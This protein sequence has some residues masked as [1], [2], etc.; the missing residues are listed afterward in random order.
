MR[1]FIL[2]AMFAT[3]LAHAAWT[4]Y[5]EV[6]DLKLDA[7]GLSELSIKAGA[8]S[9]DVKGVDGADSIEVKATIVVPNE[10]EDKALKIIEKNMT[11]SLD[12]KNGEARL[13]AWFDESFFGNGSNAHIAL[14]VSV[15]QG[16]S[17]NIDDGSGSIDVID[18]AA[19]VA[20]NDGSGSIDVSNV[21]NLEIEDGSGS[22]DVSGARGDVFIEDG[23]G[24][25]SVRHV[26]GSVII[27]DGSGSIRVSDVENDLS[28]IED[29]SGSLSFT[30]VRGTVDAET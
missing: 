18:V 24:S 27:D 1:S 26:Q 29:G 11:L 28:I 15:P 23:S 25:I 8:G 13:H 22:I 10:N 21:A 2:M 7:K 17:L 3:S 6:R 19:D 12:E 5:E 9:M 20:I 16:L 14:E 4:D 30:D